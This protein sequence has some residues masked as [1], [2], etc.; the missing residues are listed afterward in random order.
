MMKTSDY[1]NQ[2]A[3]DSPELTK[4][5]L[6]RL[7]WRS[8]QMEFSWNYERQMNL[9]YTYAMIPILKKLYKKKEDLSNALMRHL[10][11]FNTTPH[12]VTMMLG[13]SAAMEEQNAKDKNFDPSTINN[14]KASLMGPLAGLGDSF[15][16]GTLRL[17]ATGVGTS[18]ALQGSILG[19][20]LFLLIFNIPHLIVRYLLTGFGYKM[21]TGFLQRLQKS[22]AMGSLTFG[23]AV[24]GLMVIGGMSASMISIH[25]PLKIGSGEGAS[26]VQDILNNIMPGLLP[27]CA[28]G[29]IYWLLG[30]EVK[31]TTILLGIAIVGILGAWIGVFGA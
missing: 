28:F 18:L 19:P 22:G 5:D 8:F 4:K 12:I 14:V 30:K 16:W 20:I 10:E 23:A 25:V 6:R 1:E 3:T 15:F 21:G 11:F 2:D 13:V 29:I 26:G 17:I 31:A 27:L 7:F 24:L 9:A